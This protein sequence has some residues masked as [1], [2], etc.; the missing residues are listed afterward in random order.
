MKKTMPPKVAIAYAN[1]TK[2]LEDE[3]RSGKPAPTRRYSDVK[4]WGA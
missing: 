2:I 1:P 4:Y 3:E